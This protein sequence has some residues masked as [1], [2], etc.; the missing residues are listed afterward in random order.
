[1]AFLSKSFENDFIF[2]MSYYWNLFFQNTIKQL[3]KNIKLHKK[4]E[5]Y[6]L[7]SG[8]VK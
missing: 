2:M 1:M 4:F 5:A 7:Y 3:P 6:Y 8:I